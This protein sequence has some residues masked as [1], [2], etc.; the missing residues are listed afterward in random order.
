MKITY[1]G[2]AT[3]TIVVSVGAVQIKTCIAN[4]A[5]PTVAPVCTPP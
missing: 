5:T 2:S 3:G 1:D 4:L